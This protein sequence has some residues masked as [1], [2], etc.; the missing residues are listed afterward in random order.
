[1]SL[2]YRDLAWTGNPAIR[3]RFVGVCFL[4]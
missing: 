2:Y 3:M 1:M 4:K